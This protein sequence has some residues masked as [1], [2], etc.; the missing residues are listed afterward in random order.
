MFSFKT[1]NKNK[2]DNYKACYL[3][4]PKIFYTLAKTFANKS[5]Q[6]SLQHQNLWSWN[7]FVS[8][9][10]CTCL[11]STW[12]DILRDIF[13]SPGAILFEN[14]LLTRSAYLVFNLFE[15]IF[16]AAWYMLICKGWNLLVRLWEKITNSQLFFVLNV[17]SFHHC[18]EL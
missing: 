8:W 13:A 16:F 5:P 18:I 3:C 2:I 15:I 1:I 10:G 14:C 7:C 17:A 4:F 6:L 12:R 9:G 11:Q